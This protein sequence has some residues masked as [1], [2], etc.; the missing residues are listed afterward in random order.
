MN[1]ANYKNM[2]VIIDDHGREEL[3]RPAKWDEFIKTCGAGAES[4]ARPDIFLQSWQW[5]EMLYAYSR[6]IYRCV[7]ED[8]QGVWQV[9]VQIVVLPLPFGRSYFFFTARSSGCKRVGF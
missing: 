7:V 9:V 2:R 8:E 3:L 1:G 6:R 4:R 5:G